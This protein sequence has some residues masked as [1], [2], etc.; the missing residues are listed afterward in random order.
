MPDH[1]FHITEVGLGVRYAVG[2]QF[3]QVGQGIITAQQPSPVLSV[4]V[5]RCFMN[6]VFGGQYG[7]VKLNAH[8]EQLIRSRRLGETYLNM[9]T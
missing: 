9:T 1:R 8:Y 3:A 6:Q 2:E 4:Q 5:A 7:Y